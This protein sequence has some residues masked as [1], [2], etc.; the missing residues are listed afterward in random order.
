MGIKT[1]HCPVKSYTQGDRVINEYGYSQ[2]KDVNR[3]EGS[4]SFLL[5]HG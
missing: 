2:Y 1:I 5:Q 4:A 3:R